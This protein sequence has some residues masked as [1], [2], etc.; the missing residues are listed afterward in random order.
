M[1]RNSDFGIF[2]ITNNSFILSRF[3]GYDK[4]EI[5]FLFTEYHWNSGESSE[6]IGMMVKGVY[7]KI[8]INHSTVKPIKIIELTS[9]I[10]DK[11]KIKDDVE[12]L[13]YLNEIAKRKKDYL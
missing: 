2:N 6:E 4:K 13:K 9:Y 8:I 5:N 11:G 7:K 1:A 3:K 10:D 12:V